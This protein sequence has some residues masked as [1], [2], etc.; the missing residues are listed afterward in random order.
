MTTAKFLKK[1]RKK[2]VEKSYPTS[3]SDCFV[4]ILLS[5]GNSGTIYAYDAPYPTQK[6]W[7][8]FTAD[9]A[10]SLAGKPKFFFMQVKNI[11]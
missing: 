8:P 1:E 5:H 4:M 7:E 3:R 2:N 9:R 6:L 11:F 10:P